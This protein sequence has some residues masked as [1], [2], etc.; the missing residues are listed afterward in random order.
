MGDNTLIF[1]KIELKF[2]HKMLN[3]ICNTS[4]SRQHCEM[5]RFEE[6]VSFVSPAI[7]TILL[8]STPAQSGHLRSNCEGY[9]KRILIKIGQNMYSNMNLLLT[10]F[11]SVWWSVSVWKIAFNMSRNEMCHG[12]E[13]FFS[14]RPADVRWCYVRR[15]W[16]EGFEH[17]PI[18][19]N[20]VRTW[21]MGPNLGKV[22]HFLDLNEWQ[23]E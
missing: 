18:R 6:I 14:L 8:C 17:W 1:Q 11:K 5:Y 13:F 9:E 10:Y 21:P 12:I 16:L 19:P 23:P 7:M 22:E 3:Y 4:P 15:D 2:L 20:H